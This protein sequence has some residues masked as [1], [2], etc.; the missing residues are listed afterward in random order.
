ML[1]MQQSTPKRKSHSSLPG[2]SQTIDQIDAMIPSR[3]KL[4]TD[5]KDFIYHILNAKGPAATPK[6]IASHYN[7]IMM[8]GAVTTATFLSGVMYYLGHNRRPLADCRMSC[9]AHSRASRLSIARVCWI[10]CIWTPWLRRGWG[11][12]RQLVQ[13]ICPGSSQRAGVR[14]REVLFQKAYVSSASYSSRSSAFSGFFPSSFT[15]P[16]F[17]DGKPPHSRL[18]LPDSCISPP[19]VRPPRSHQLPRALAVHPGALD[20]DHYRRPKRR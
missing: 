17:I 11:F 19:L 5:R 12:I 16:S 8:A 2:I 20:L 6:E 7:V 18:P 14:F 9:A 1:S 13:R 4:Q 15:I 3:L 10:A